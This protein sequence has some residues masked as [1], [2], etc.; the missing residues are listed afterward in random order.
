LAL[1]A[2]MTEGT[3]LFDQYGPGGG[4]GWRRKFGHTGTRTSRL[5]ETGTKLACYL[6]TECDRGRSTIIHLPEECDTM[7]EVLPKIQ[8]R[9]HLDGR[10]LYASEL[11]LPSGEKI[12]TFKQL[13]EAAEKDTA[14]IVGC[15]EP[16][17]PSTV[18]YDILEFHLHGGGRYA[19][20]QVKKE[21]HDKRV[22]DAHD[23]AE[24]VRASGHG[25][26]PNSIAVATARQNTVEQHH[27]QAAYMRHEYM[28]QLMFRASQQ[29]ELMDRV[30]ENN[31]MHKLEHAESKVRR[32]EMERERMEKL[33]R[34]REESQKVAREKKVATRNRILLYHNKVK[35][36]YQNSAARLRAQRLAR[37]SQ[38][39]SAVEVRL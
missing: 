6:N 3:S 22:L 23:K 5:R 14:I 25:L 36:D 9:M 18:P 31:L 4:S 12:I 38:A 15:G 26:T 37:I 11:F 17:D 8:A 35:Q 19:A 16:F 10:M 39:G 2:A 13:V 30:Q 21:L 20:R 27:G 1:A 24:T 7:A 32:A 28:E 29:K 34:E 33:A